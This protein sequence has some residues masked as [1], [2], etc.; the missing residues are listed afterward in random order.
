[1]TDEWWNAFSS[2]SEQQLAFVK[3]II[4]KNDFSNISTITSDKNIINLL[5]FYT[6]SRNKAAEDIKHLNPK[7]LSQKA[8]IKKIEQANV[9]IRATLV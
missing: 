5:K 8:N 4:H 7:E 6:I 9:G 3:P 2:L 1:M